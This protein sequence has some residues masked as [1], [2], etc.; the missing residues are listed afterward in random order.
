MKSGSSEANC[1]TGK[2][3]RKPQENLLNNGKGQTK[4]FQFRTRV[5]NYKFRM[6]TEINLTGA[7][8]N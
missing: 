6:S 3:R 1:T 5:L 4:K 8:R 2:K 7:S